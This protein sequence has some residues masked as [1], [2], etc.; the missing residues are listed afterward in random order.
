MQSVDYLSI[1]T[2]RTKASCRT[3]RVDRLSL[4][5]SAAKGYKL[6]KVVPLGKALNSPRERVHYVATFFSGG[7]VLKQFF[8][9]ILT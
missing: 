4:K 7:S 6:A 8:V 5:I 9:R 2:G 1:T 3:P